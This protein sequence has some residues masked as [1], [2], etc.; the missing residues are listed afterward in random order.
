MLVAFEVNNFFKCRTKGRK[1]Y[2]ALK[3][4]VSKAYDRIGWL[5]LQRVLLRLVFAES[6]V[7]SIM[8][9]V[10]TV[11]YSFLLNGKQ[12]GALQPVR[13]LRQGDPLSP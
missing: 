6:F 8:L 4:D 9:C 12:L 10:N 13:G 11:S 1:Q 2:M 3:L 5:F 7:N